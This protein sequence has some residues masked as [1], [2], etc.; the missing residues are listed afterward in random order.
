MGRTSDTSTELIKKEES[1]FKNFK[2]ALRQEDQKHLDTL[3]ASVKRHTAAISMAEHA[4]P[5]ENMLLV[6]L[7]EQQKRIDYLERKLHGR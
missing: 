3:F 6:M 2:R 1:K 4:L 5:L 7:L